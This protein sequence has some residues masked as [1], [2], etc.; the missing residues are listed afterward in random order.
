MIGNKR[1]I[2]KSKYLLIFSIV[3]LMSSAPAYI[4]FSNNPHMKKSIHV[5][6]ENMQKFD[7][8]KIT[9]KSGK[10]LKDKV[11]TLCEAMIK[12]A[13]LFTICL[14]IGIVFN[15]LMVSVFLFLISRVYKKLELQ[16]AINDAK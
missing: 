6:Q 13:E 10:Y 16:V 14:T 8:I 4:F 15:I 2:N 7:N 1:K 9:T 11:H 5:I 3:F 12:Y